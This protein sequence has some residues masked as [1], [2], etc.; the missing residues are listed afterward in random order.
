MQSGDGGVSWSDVQ[1]D[2]LSAGVCG[3]CTASSL[4]SSGGGGDNLRQSHGCTA[5]KRFLF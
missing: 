4:L 1:I 2:R 5:L 3:G